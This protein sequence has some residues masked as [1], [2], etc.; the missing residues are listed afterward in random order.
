MVNLIVELSRRNQPGEDFIIELLVDCG[1]GA[2]LVNLVAE[3]ILEEPHSRLERMK[4]KSG[5]SF[6][7]LKKII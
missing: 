4:N 3:T 5:L 6:R 2:G 1:D 7:N